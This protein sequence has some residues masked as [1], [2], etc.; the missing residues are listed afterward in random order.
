MDISGESLADF[1]NNIATQSLEIDMFREHIFIEEVGELLVEAG[2]I[3]DFVRCSYQAR[4]VRVDGYS[5]DE[6]LGVLNLV[7]SHYLDH[8]DISNIRVT[9]TDLETYFKRCSNFYQRSVKNLFEKIDIANEAHDLSKLIKEVGP[10]FHTVNII[11]ITDGVAPKQ[12]ARIDE[13]DGVE[14]RKIIWDIERILGFIEKGEREVITVNFNDNGGS[15]PSLFHHDSEGIYTTYLTFISG[16][17]L[18]DLYSEWGTRM[19]DMNVRV[20]LSARGKINRGIRETILNDS[21]MFC[22][23][24]NG[25]TVFAREVVVEEISGNS[26]VI[27]GATD[28]QIVNGGQTVASL[29]HASRKQ[30]ADLSQI[31]VQMKLILIIDE[32]NIDRLVPRI[33]EYS[34]MQNRVSLAD[35]S[36]NDPPHPELHDISKNLWAPDPTGG[37]KLT[38]WFYEKARGSYEE[39]KRLEAR[40]TAQGKKFEA[41]YPKK[42]R[43]DKSIFGKVWNTYLRKPHDVSLGAQK[44]FAKFN[45]W[46]R[47]QDEDLAEFFKKTVA[48]VLLWKTTEK[49]VRRQTFQGYRHNI[50][51]YTLS[52]LFE[53]SE[54]KIDLYKIWHEQ[55]IPDNLQDTI[56]VISHVVN[57]H[58]RDTDLNIS[59]WCKKE[60][61]WE[62]LRNKEFVL[63]DDIKS[64]YIKRGR[65]QKEY[66]PQIKQERET[67]EY[68]VDKGSDAWW[69]LASWLKEWQYLTPKARSQCGNM[70][71]TIGREK[72][73][74]YVLSRACKKIWEDALVR[75]WTCPNNEDR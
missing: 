63:P 59:E 70:A 3:D 69:G 53:L 29:F 27:E 60:N 5:F 41:R 2:E 49:I 55:M 1:H 72:E 28:F 19:L 36:A 64:I 68:C 38:H 6:D 7:V 31:A 12:A 14:I 43:F 45:M 9:K 71:R 73:P 25:I 54:M 11:L 8:D 40:T 67:I 61:C 50:V 58:I 33:S 75:G 17:C 52:W 13:F 42:Q 16:Q 37:S 35:L 30:M 22:A 10:G 74:S 44:N 18:A 56:E 62:N 51:T 39:T 47:E 65:K 46:L 57:D 66:D 34:N 26:C 4:G 24:N 20:Y 15:L 23:Y 21:D 32:K 48:L